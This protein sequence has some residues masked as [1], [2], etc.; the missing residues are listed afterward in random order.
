[1]A[2]PLISQTDYY[3]KSVTV[4]LLSGCNSETLV[5]FWR[6]RREI[7]EL[8]YLWRWGRFEIPHPIVC[9][10]SLKRSKQDTAWPLPG[11]GTLLVSIH[12]IPDTFLIQSKR[13][14]EHQWRERPEKTRT[15]GSCSWF[16][17]KKKGP[18]K[19]ELIQYVFSSYL[20]LSVQNVVLNFFYIENYICRI[21]GAKQKSLLVAGKLAKML[22]N[23][24]L[25]VAKE[26]A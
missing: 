19:L 9:E 23:K 14:S 12:W 25:N 15:L 1:M 17:M 11:L 21:H 6:K 24:I 16:L 4:K 22:C 10:Q 5:C 2:D 13:E 20:F 18:I 7:C 3:S 26:C 8:N